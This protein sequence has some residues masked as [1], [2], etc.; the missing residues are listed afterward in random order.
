VE[1]RGRHEEQMAPRL[2]KLTA[3]WK[4]FPA[5]DIPELGGMLLCEFFKKKVLGKDE[6]PLPG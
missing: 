6:R 3:G 1:G 4:S 5:E 2:Q